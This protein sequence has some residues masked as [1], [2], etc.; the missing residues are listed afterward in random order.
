LRRADGKFEFNRYA[1]WH[2]MGTESEVNEKLDSYGM[3]F[4]Q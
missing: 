2:M 3:N 4:R 1:F